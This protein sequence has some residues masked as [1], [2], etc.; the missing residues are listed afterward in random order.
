MIYTFCNWEGI[1]NRRLIS[2]FTFW[3]EKRTRPLRTSQMHH[4]AWRWGC[5]VWFWFFDHIRY[6]SQRAQRSFDHFR[7]LCP[8]EDELPIIHW[9]LNMATVLDPPWYVR[10]QA[11]IEFSLGLDHQNFHQCVEWA[12][13]YW[14]WVSVVI[15]PASSL[16]RRSNKWTQLFPTKRLEI[17]QN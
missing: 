5:N 3:W 9:N 11:K 7:S 14:E 15:Q 12:E 17:G 4:G 2:Q 13:M 1:S 6:S 16:L 8:I 10:F